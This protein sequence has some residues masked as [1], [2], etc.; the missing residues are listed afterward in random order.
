MNIVFIAA[1]CILVFGMLNGLRKGLIRTV[2]STFIIFAALAIAA[3]GSSYAAKFLKTTPLYNT[4]H[5]QIEGVI[6]NEI[7]AGTDEVTGQIDAINNLPFPESIKK[8]LIENNNSKIYE[9]LGIDEFAAY[10]ADYISMV[11]MKAIA[12][13]ALFF[14][15]FIILKIIE[16][17]LSA[18]ASLPVLNGLNRAGGFIFGLVNGLMTIWFFFII[19]T[20]FAGTSWGMEIFRQIND[21]VLLSFIY[22]NNYLM[23]IIINISKL[24]F[25]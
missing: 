14:L 5:T 12:F 9:A 2:F 25:A 3:Y 4:V 15:A 13:A 21:S 7:Q 18:V 24:V 10:I 23:A 22:N 17:C 19:I 6:N 20:I 1:V 16:L 11:I 8:G